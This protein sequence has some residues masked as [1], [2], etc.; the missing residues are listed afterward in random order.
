MI[1][2]QDIT[3]LKKVF[4]TKADLAKTDKRVNKLQETVGD[5]KVEM[6]ELNDKVDVLGEKVDLVIEKLDS[7]TENIHELWTD[8]NAGGVILSRHTK[9]IQ[10]LAHHTEMTLPE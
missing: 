4:A 5:L 7:I 9:Q 1:T 6:G 10:A 8:N 3:K 2:E